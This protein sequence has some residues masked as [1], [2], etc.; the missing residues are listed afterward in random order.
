MDKTNNCEIFSLSS[1]L[2]ALNGQFDNEVMDATYQTKELHGGTLGNVYLVSGLA[3]MKDHSIKP[4]QL[5]F[6]KQQ[7][8]ERY[9]D[10]NSWRREYDLYRSDLQKEYTAD[11]RWPKCY[12]HILNEDSFELWLEYIDAPSG[13]NLTL[14]M[15]I[16]AAEALGRFQGKLYKNNSDILKQIN[17]L[18]TKEYVKKFYLHFK[19]WKEVYDYIHADTCDLPKHLCKMLIDVDTHETEIFQQ[20]DQLPVVLCHRDYWNENIFYLN[21]QTIAIDWDTTGYG[22]FG[23]DIASLIADET[24]SKIMKDLFR[25]CIPAY[26]KGFSEYVEVLSNISLS[27]YNLILLMFGYR[28]VASY[29]FAE[30]QAGKTLAKDTLQ[31]IYDLKALI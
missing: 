8:W 22:Y 28:L 17:N 30:D 21:G 31:S 7:K 5:V 11:F 1:L 20:L 16:K 6:K 9:G 26:Q 13:S 24:D 3:T 23:E 19:S 10:I 2:S 14:P 12:H 25:L 18:S 4:Y 29:K 15:Y 27:I